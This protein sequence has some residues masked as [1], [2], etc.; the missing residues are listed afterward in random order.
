MR[1][2]A[3]ES[4]ELFVGTPERPL[5]VV[6]AEIEHVPGRSVRVT[7]EGRGVGETVV[8]VGEN[9]TVRAEIP[10]TGDGGPITVTATDGDESAHSTGEFTVAEPGWTMFM[11]SHF[12][13]DPVWWNTQGAYTETWD[14]VD[15]PAATG[16]PAR[17]FGYRGDSGMSLVRAHSDLA[18][19]DPAYTF[20]LAEVDYLK[21]YWD[22]FPEERAFLRELIRTGRVEVMG[23]TYNEPN[24]N[25]TGAEATVRNALYGDGFQRGIMGA[26]PQTAWQLDAF[27]HDP[28]F[29]G[30][31]ADAGV[32]S[33]SWA[34]GPHHQ[35]GPTMSVF[36]EEPR[37]PGRMQF[38]AEFEWIAPSGRGLLT[39][40]MVN[41]YAAGWAIDSA[42]A[43]PEAEAAA[44]KLFNGLK[45][46][47]LTRNVLLPV[48]GDYAPPCRWVMDIHRDWNARYVWPRFVSA[49][50]RDFFAAVRAELDAEGRRASPQTR[51]MNPVYTGKDVSY[52]DTKQAQRHGETLLA[53]AEA[54]A[55]LAS[56]VT[57]HAYPDAALDKAWRHL[58]YGAH[59]D[60]ITGSESDQVYIDL[61]TGWRELTDLAETVHADATRALAD[62]VEPG[63][64]PDLVVFNPAT[65]ERRDVLTVD[66]PGLVPVGD[67]FQP[68]PAVREQDG[69]LRVVVPQV[70]GMGLKTLPLAA[71]S[72]PG[73]TSGEG[74]TIRNEFYEVT[75]DAARGGAVSSLR[76]VAEGGRELLPAGEI[77]NELVVQE[78]FPRHPRFGEGPWHLTPTGTTAARG[79]DVTADIEVDHSPA[80][81]RITVRADLG[82]FTY[83]QRLTLW[84]GVDRLDVATTIDGYDGADRLIRVRWPSDVRGGLPVHEVA[85]AVIG[86]GFGFVE[87]D[88]E[89]FP[90]TLDNPANTWFALGST[91]R[92]LLHDDSGAPLGRR[93][94][95]VAELV[96]ADWDEAGELGTPLAAA[97]V[98]AGVTAT[99]TIAGG[100][101]YGDLEVDSNLPDIRIAVGGPGHNSLVAEALAMDPAAD[102]ELRRQVAERGVAAVWVAP[103]ASLREEWVPGADLRDLERLPL[104]VIAGADPSGDAKAVDALIA[105]LEDFTVTA[106]A[107]G[108]GEALPPGDAWDGRGFAVLNRGTPGCVVTSSGDLYMSLMRSCTGWPS[109]I[110]IDPP[111]RTTPDGSGFQL[112]R[113]SHT[114]EYAVVAGEGDWRDLRLPARGHEFNHPLTARVRGAGTSPLLPRKTSLLTVEPAR[115]V[116]LDALKPLGSPLAR[117]GTT[118]ADPGRG[119]VVR[120]HEVNGRPVRARVRGPVA[121][122]E[123]ARADVLERPGESLIPDGEGA[124]EAELTGFEVATV[125][126]TPPLAPEP[127]ADPGV[128]A[129]EPAQPVHTRYWLHN[130]G[131]APRGNMPVSVYLSPTA[132]TASGPISATVRVSSEL[133]DTS[134]KGT[135]V[136]EVPPGWSAEP[137]ELPYALGPGG[138][139]LAEVTVTPPPDAG[140]GRHW[141]TA[142]LSY[143]G[144]IY[145]DVVGL[146]VPGGPPA[147]QGLACELNADRVTVRRGERAHVPV[148]LRNTT[149]GPVGGQL[150]AVSSWGTWRGVG[151]GLRGFTV[152]GGEQVE[153]A[154]EVDGS[155]IPPGSYWLLA[156]AAWNGQVAYTKAIALEVTS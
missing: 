66:D 58:V 45:K 106:T 51:D 68:L 128:A 132:L 32:T 52:I 23:G 35:W 156:K 37:D 69:T 84:A 12:H 2:T 10:V 74:T 17:P 136:F 137:A 146:D 104:L 152:P 81:S 39:A 47:A 85:D 57:G 114:F 25:L 46:V 93:A 34:R 64:G 56:L 75:V 105:D 115:E 153:C 154:I 6:A 42:P 13:Y 16:L 8:T 80:G 59:H 94:I 100:P 108:G 120:V 87:V 101:R 11:V 40:Y 30:L 109:G 107:P 28:Q 9:G 144:Q 19:R 147:G 129:H 18:R 135:V 97:L 21:P 14:V 138:F 62:R 133:T 63:T 89:Q 86:R 111:R 92:V 91:A 150:W 48:G 121:W 27:G 60:A 54:W 78:E 99:S 134:T 122:T 118:P 50:P 131:P 125:L 103:R 44:L 96:Y 38:P 5:Q 15:D 71:G 24:T 124:L 141:L 98:R 70:P 1:V 140:P 53:D 26:S 61:L 77:G 151:P 90:W 79:R 130:S 112:Q 55:T 142:R 126:A 49:V 113:W 155:A 31:M 76:A 22:A 65:W 20:V 72:L 95:G 116:L 43:L 82:L 3:V 88:S 127:K 41:H 148:S 67:D 102:R 29:P 73:W 143:G 110:W 117:G 33:S 4:T 139:S 149:R 7:V 83:T 145:E 123:G 36:G 119:V